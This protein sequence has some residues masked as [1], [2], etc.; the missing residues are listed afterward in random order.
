MLFCIPDK[1][2]DV[3]NFTCVSKNWESLN[4]SWSVPENPVKVTYLLTYV[5]QDYSKDPRYAFLRNGKVCFFLSER[6][7]N[8]QVL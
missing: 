3:Q 1:P 7:V 5:I 2:Q 6:G 8:E 4:C